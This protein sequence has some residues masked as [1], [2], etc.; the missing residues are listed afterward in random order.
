M[1]A[2]VT[3][4]QL[5]QRA[6]KLIDLVAAGG[7]VGITRDGR[8]VA[9]LARPGSGP[10]PD[11]GRRAREGLV[12]DGTVAPENAATARGLADWTFPEPGTGLRSA[13]DALLTMREEKD[14]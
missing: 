8:L 4:R 14:R 6:D 3:V 7:R 11:P 10:E 1:T 13:S 9:V 5:Q 2:R 12:H